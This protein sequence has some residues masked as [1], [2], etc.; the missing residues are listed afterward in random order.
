MDQSSLET[1]GRSAGEEIPSL[2][3]NSKIP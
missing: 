2:L 1:D 3:R